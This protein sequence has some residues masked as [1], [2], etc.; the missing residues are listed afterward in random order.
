MAAFFSFLAIQS[1]RVTFSA[2]LLVYSVAKKYIAANSSR[3]GSGRSKCREQR[4]PP[5]GI[6]GIRF[7]V[8]GNCF[9]SG[10]PSVA[11]FL[12]FDTCFLLGRGLHN[13]LFFVT[14]HRRTL[15]SDFRCSNSRISTAG[16]QPH[17][18]AATSASV[19]VCFFIACLRRFRPVFF[20]PGSCSIAGSVLFFACLV[21]DL[22]RAWCNH[23]RFLK[24]S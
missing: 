4:V 5:K 6:R 22:R 7:A 10:A 12:A 24:N 18:V 11:S 1:A 16:L 2:A 21:I 17:G 9:P 8:A 14:A 13:V 3:T 23:I 15:G 20:C 19:T